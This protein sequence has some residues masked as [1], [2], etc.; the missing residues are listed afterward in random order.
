VQHGPAPRPLE[1]FEV[2]LTRD[3]KLKVDKDRTVPASYRL[4]V[5]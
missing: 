5:S 2:T 1:W 4:M 3:G